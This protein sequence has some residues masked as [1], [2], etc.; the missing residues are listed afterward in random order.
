LTNANEPNELVIQRVPSRTRGPVVVAAVL[1]VAVGL[2][3]AK[4]WDVQPAPAVV[5]IQPTNNPAASTQSALPEPSESPS[6]RTTG[7]P[8]PYPPYTPTPSPAPSELATG[9]TTFVE[10]QPEGE[11]ATCIYERRQRRFELAAIEV[12]APRAYVISDRG[13][14]RIRNVVWWVEVISNQEQS[15]FGDDWQPVTE[16]GLEIAAAID[17]QPANFTDQFLNLADSDMSATE[18]IRARVVVDW[19]SFPG[20]TIPRSAIDHTLYASSPIPIAAPRTYCPAV[21]KGRG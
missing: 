17:G 9:D 11:L 21:I 15:L 4:P 6:P 10:F 8:I 18:V 2:L 19:P 3:I 12:P 16:S 7:T 1:V 5:A 14:G 20:E 13:T